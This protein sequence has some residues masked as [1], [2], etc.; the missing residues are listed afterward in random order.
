MGFPLIVMLHDPTKIMLGTKRLPKLPL[1]FGL[2]FQFFIFCFPG[3]LLLISRARRMNIF[4][5]F[6][7]IETT[8][9][10]LLSKNLFSLFVLPSSIAEYFSAWLLTTTPRQLPAACSI[11]AHCISLT[12]AELVAFLVLYCVWVYN[13][14]SQHFRTFKTWPS[15]FSRVL[16][17][18][19]LPCQA[20]S[21]VLCCEIKLEELS[22]DTENIHIST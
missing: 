7:W 9:R 8:L 20:E 3:F 10:M 17:S 21:K 16:K 11:T 6:I 15:C 4:W 12:E 14:A 13:R 18:W 5:D 1:S 2:F 22:F 19:V